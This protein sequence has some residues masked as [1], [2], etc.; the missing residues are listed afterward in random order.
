MHNMTR[1]FIRLATLLLSVALLAAC[2]Q[3][4]VEVTRVIEVEKQVTATVEVTRI[5]TL[6]REVEAT[7]IVEVT[8]TATPIPSGGY[9]VA[10]VPDE[11]TTFNPLLA[12][13]APSQLVSSFI[14][15]GMVT[16]DPFG[17]QVV[18]HFC[19]E[20]Q[21]VDRTYTFRL[22]DDLSWSDGNPITS[23]D[24]VYTWAALFW[25]AAHETLET[26]LLD[27]AETVES[28][29]KI[30]DQTVAVTMREARCGDLRELGIGWLPRHLYG[31]DWEIGPNR[32]VS[33]SGPFGDADDPD[34]AGIG[35]HALNQTPSVSSGPF[36]FREWSAG[37]HVT[38]TRNVTY[39]RGAP[40]LDGLVIRIIADEGDRVQALRTGEIDLLTDLEPEYL[41]RIE[42]M[43]QLAVTKTLG[44]SYFYLGLQL[45]DPENPQARWLEDENSGDPVLNEAHGEHPILGDKRVRQAIAFGID[46]HALI[47]QAALGQGV[48]LDGNM[49]PSVGWAYHDGLE[50]REYDP[51]RAAALL[52]EA[53][54]VL[55]A[56]TGIR[57]KEGRRLALSLRTNLSSDARVQIG[58]LIQSQLGGL[59]FEI[60]FEA[61]EWGAF[62][63]LLLG[64]RFDMV[65]MSWTE[66]ASGLEDFDQPL[67]DSQNDVPN[68]GYNF[69]S[70][71]NPSVDELWRNASGLPGC[72]AADRRILYQ[73]IQAILHDELPYVW[74][75]A[76]LKLTG[77][78]RRLVGINPGPWGL[79]YNVETWHLAGE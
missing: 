67:F 7:R 48:P 35:N 77:A 25:A 45:G 30:D 14:Y 43:S 59:G 44:D 73:Q 31:P 58:E 50:R 11:F 72:E 62:V 54:W 18:C 52:E 57:E 2:G 71:F 29:T 55:N 51:E 74:L 4:A 64:Q 79:W 69:V 70:Y 8:P 65:V 16:L 28:I 56:S 38:L 23:D 13:D 41:T 3:R 33:R 76:P 68:R 12:A 36:L 49:L 66:I 34:F 32:P 26:P 19:R 75:Y 20:W 63:G 9:V 39:F 60:S 5:V 1:I 27:V 24:F 22:R 17:G 6:E 78:D 10:A 15:G 46:R 61:L 42:L 47:N 53:G 40:H 21:L 37:D